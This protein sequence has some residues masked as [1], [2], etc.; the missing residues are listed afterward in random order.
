MAR[1]SK[2][3]SPG[4]RHPSD[5]SI[6]DALLPPPRYRHLP[7]I[8]S[9]RHNTAEVYLS[10]LTTL[11]PYRFPLPPILQHWPV[12]PRRH[13][14]IHSGILSVGWLLVFLLY[15]SVLSI[16]APSKTSSVQAS[17]LSSGCSSPCGVP[18]L[19]LHFITRALNLVKQGHGSEW[20]SMAIHLAR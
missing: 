10:V 15:S 4:P 13:I 20:K 8:S 1:I 18:N 5:V 14:T 19:L 11:R 12:G 3:K 16:P 9:E 7:A 2:Q 6:D 17:P